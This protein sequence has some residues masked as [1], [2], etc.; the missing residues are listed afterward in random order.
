MST[1]QRDQFAR[2]LA[3]KTSVDDRA[4]NARVWD[5]LAAELRGRRGRP[6]AVLEVGCGIGTMIERLAAHGMLDDAVYT[7]LDLC[8]DNLQRARERLPGGLA[9]HGW[10]AAE[11][12]AARL[13]FG[14]GAHRLEIALVPAEVRG[15]LA[16]LPPASFDLVVAHA[17]LDVVDADT[18]LPLVA[19]CLRPRGL[20]YLSLCFDGLTAV[21]PGLDPDLDARIEGR[22][23]ATMD[24]RLRDGEPAGDCRSGR[25]L[26][27]RLRRSGLDLLAAGGGDWVVFA[28]PPSGRGDPSYRGDEGFFLHYLIDV[29]GGALGGDASFVRGEVD[30]WVA[31]RHAQVDR[32]ELVW[33]SHN[34][35]LLARARE[36]CG[37]HA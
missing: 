27:G 6:L 22:Y 24:A 12:T 13:R 26:F 35:D 30:S 14:R 17:V 2:Y 4:L 28:D 32:G 15:W 33:I 3:A 36:G 23:H 25:H 18:L 16:G 10:M 8:E 20:A 9:A 29:V 1:P 34:L 31:T 7:A 21:E 19:G 11:L 5:T 37:R